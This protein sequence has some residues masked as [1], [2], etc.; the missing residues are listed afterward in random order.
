MRVS[1]AR[2]SKLPGMFR[3]R[4]YYAAIRAITGSHV[5]AAHR[6]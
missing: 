6:S 5:D 3:F 1:L 4:V 2:C